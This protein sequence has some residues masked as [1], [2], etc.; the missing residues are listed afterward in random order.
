V[1]HTAAEAH[2]F[3]RWAGLAGS[4]SLRRL[5]WLSNSWLLGIKTL[6]VLSRRFHWVNV[7]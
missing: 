1:P 2:S 6:F 4:H 3:S 5:G 7:G